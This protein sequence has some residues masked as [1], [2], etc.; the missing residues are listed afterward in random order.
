MKKYLLIIIILSIITSCSVDDSELDRTIFIPDENN[1]K[2]PAYTEWGY[3]SF[4]AKYERTYFLASEYITPCKIAWSNDSLYL[5]ISGVCGGS[6]MSLTFIFPSDTIKNYRELM[7]LHDTTINLS[8]N[9]QVIMTTENKD[10]T[11]MLTEG[12][13][14]FKRVQILSVDDIVSRSILSGTFDIKF[15]TTTVFTESF[16]DGRFDF[17]ITNNEFTYLN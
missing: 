5:L 1:H 6:N 2:L 7:K 17:G 4:G 10:D 11:L 13:I 14:H 15:R 3:N 16:S 8:S 12:N 9:S